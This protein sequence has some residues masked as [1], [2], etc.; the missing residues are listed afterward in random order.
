MEK[1]DS[2]AEMIGQDDDSNVIS[3]TLLHSMALARKENA[4]S[5]VPLMSEL[6]IKGNIS[7]VM[8]AGYE[9]TA[10]TL[11]W[12]LYMLAKHHDVQ[13]KLQDE[14]D[15][16]L[17]CVLDEK[18]WEDPESILESLDSSNFPYASAVLNET[19]RL[20][21][22]APMLGLE[23]NSNDSIRVLGHDIPQKSMVFMLFREASLKECPSPNPD[24]FDPSRWLQKEDD[25]DE[26][27]ASFYRKMMS[28]LL[29]FGGG[30]RI[31]PGTISLIIY[32][33]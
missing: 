14:V 11:M 20:K 31:C 26:T 13:K 3:R 10:G 27:F 22:V 23:A 12:V 25:D 5:K 21:P 2:K 33:Y 17:G 32:T 18:F 8:L 30:P 24:I 9:T 16:V 29:G 7:Q 4:G 6:K 19:I 15:S 28:Q 1:I